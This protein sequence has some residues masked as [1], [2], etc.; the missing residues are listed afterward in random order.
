VYNILDVLKDIG[1]VL[2][3]IISIFKVVVIPFS[4]INFYIQAISTMFI[5][6]TKDKTVFNFAPIKELYVP[7]VDEAVRLK[8]INEIRKIQSK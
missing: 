2:N 4:F 1:G 5:A 8:P 3:S 7:D 6:R